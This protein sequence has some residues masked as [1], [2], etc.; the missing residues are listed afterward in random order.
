MAARPAWQKNAYR[1]VYLASPLKFRTSLHAFTPHLPK[2]FIDPWEKDFRAW[3]RHKWK[4]H[5]KRAKGKYGYTEGPLTGVRVEGWPD[6]GLTGAH[7]LA[8]LASRA[9]AEGL[10]SQEF[11]R[12]L[13]ERTRVLR[14]VVSVGDLAAILDALVSAEI[15]HT[16]L[17]RTLTRELVDDVDKL[18]FVELAVVANAYAHFNCVSE[19]LLR[20]M[21]GH[22][23]RLLLD[24]DEVA[25]DPRSLA[26]LLKAFAKL[27]YKSE[28]AMTAMNAAVVGFAQEL[29][30]ADLADALVAFA[31][32]QWDFKAPPQFWDLAAAKVGGSRMASLCPAL[33]ASALLRA[34]LTLAPSPPSSSSSSPPPQDRAGGRAEGS[35]A[36]TAES[37]PPGTSAS[38]LR[39]AL[40]AE[41]L[42]GLRETPTGLAPSRLGAAFDRARLPAFAESSLHSQLLSSPRQDELPETTPE[43]DDEAAVVVDSP[44]WS[45]AEVGALAGS[46]G[47]FSL[48]DAPGLSAA[49]AGDVVNDMPVDSVEETRQARPDRW[50]NPSA[51]RPFAAAIPEPAFAPF[52][53]AALFSRN[54]RGELV[55]EAVE[56]LGNIWRLDSETSGF[57]TAPALEVELL[58]MASPVIKSSV[59]GLSAKQLAACAEA[60]SRVPSQ[61]SKETVQCLV[62]EAIRKL[63]NFELAD[64]RRL[65]DAAVVLGVDDPY[66]DRARMRKFPKALRVELRYR[67]AAPSTPLQ[68]PPPSG[69]E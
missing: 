59:P 19:P 27:E 52:D 39:S 29:P 68:P 40:V 33:R 5:K 45:T 1:A 23:A 60:Y 3:H 46:T 66:L 17:M 64:L 4:V 53:A 12:S 28:E 56:G 10:Q 54:R 44:G 7:D 38:G 18:T 62:Q 2:F 26:V 22:T 16:D 24:P 15:R 6:P 58:Q 49:G 50:Y 47:R 11:W 36:P 57:V 8:L 51:R 55:A 42:A 41:I 34:P 43:I 65:H 14:D 20:A 9:Q 37:A 48:E 13:A 21:A 31:A 67:K 69:A 32:L 61:Q 63:S 25:R 35:K 30:F